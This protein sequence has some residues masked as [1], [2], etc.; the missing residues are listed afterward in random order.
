MWLQLQ[1]AGLAAVR[2]GLFR[3]MA[4]AEARATLQGRQLG[5]AALRLLPK[6][7][8]AALDGPMC[9]LRMLHIPLRGAI[10]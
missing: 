3:P 5:I 7:T 6:R 1:R 4:P 2:D 10:C 8:G 9:V